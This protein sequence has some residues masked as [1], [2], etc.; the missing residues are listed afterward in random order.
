MKLKIGDTLKWTGYSNIRDIEYQI[1][2][3]DETKSDDQICFKWN[4]P[5]FGENHVAWY[6]RQDTI[7]KLI[8]SGTISINKEKLIPFKIEKHKII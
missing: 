1:I 8:K 3:I 2:D 6:Y 4:S 5:I 7:L